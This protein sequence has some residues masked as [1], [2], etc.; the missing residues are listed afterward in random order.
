MH[1]IQALLGQVA[2]FLA[3]IQII[4]YIRS[5]L[6]GET[7]PSRTSYAIWLAVE[8]VLVTSYF[9]VG[10]TTTKWMYVIIF[11]NSLVLFLLSLKYG[12]KGFH[13]VD[14]VS[15]VFAVAAIVAW[16]STDNPTLAVYLCTAASFFGYIPTERKSYS[17][18]R[19]ENKLSWGLYVFAA[20]L[21]VCALTT[22]SPEIA[23]PP[24][25]SFVMSG[26]V[27]LL[28]QNK[29]NK[30]LH[31]HMIIRMHTTVRGR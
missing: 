1:D 12:M 17:F 28:L 23:L 9:S 6:R 3:I 26:L 29:F 19:T 8:L 4:P 18:P 7:K 24:I 11:L 10:A 15:I 16:V 30:S 25:V 27:F 14:L 2:A 21:N 13:K 20:F 5:I 22:L 31:R